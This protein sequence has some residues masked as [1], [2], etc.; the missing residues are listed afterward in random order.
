MENLL[1]L[2]DTKGKVLDSPNAAQLVF[3]PGKVDFKDVSFA[4]QPGLDVLSKVS[5]TTNSSCSSS[6][7]S[8]SMYLLTGDVRPV[9]Q[10]VVVHAM[11]KSRMSGSSTR[12]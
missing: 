6:S 5:G 11:I 4:Y 9:V 10:H 2:L 1:Q 3:G 12:C 7:S 8:S